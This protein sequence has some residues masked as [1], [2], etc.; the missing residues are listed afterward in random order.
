MCTQNAF[1]YGVRACMRVVVI[2][3]HVSDCNLFLCVSPRG[4]NVRERVLGRLK[5]RHDAVQSEWAPPAP[6]PAAAWILFWYADRGRLTGLPC[7]LCLYLSNRGERKAILRGADNNWSTVR[8]N[9]AAVALRVQVIFSHLTRWQ[10]LLSAMTVTHFSLFNDTSSWMLMSMS[11]YL[12][13]Q[14]NLSIHSGFR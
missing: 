14:L 12:D 6:A 3:L 7:S 13:Y 4:M 2:C 5:V 10:C 8:L 9:W 1:T 11:S